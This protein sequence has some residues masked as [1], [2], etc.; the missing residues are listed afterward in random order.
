[1]V[2]GDPV[3]GRRMDFVV[4]ETDTWI[5]EMLG[6]TLMTVGYVVEY[7]FSSLLDTSIIEVYLTEF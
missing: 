7:S 4:G 2:E 5:L 3:P 6:G 1:M